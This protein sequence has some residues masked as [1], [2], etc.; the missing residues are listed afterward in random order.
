ME[1]RSIEDILKNVYDTWSESTSGMVL[2]VDEKNT[3][4]SQILSLILNEIMGDDMQADSVGL[5]PGDGLSERVLE[6]GREWYEVDLGSVCEVKGIDE[7]QR[8]DYVIPL[9]L[10]IPEHV[11]ES[12]ER[13]LLYQDFISTGC[14]SA[15][16]LYEMGK[17]ICGELGCEFGVDE[18]HRA[19]AKRW[20]E[21]R[22][23]D[24]LLWRLTQEREGMPTEE[25]WET[26]YQCTRDS[27]SGRRYDAAEV[28]GIRCNGMDEER[29]RRLA[30]DGDEL[31]RVNAVEH[32]AHGVQEKTLNVLYERMRKG[33][34]MVR[35]YAVKSFFDVW[36]NR[37]G[38][39]RTSVRKC[40][41]KMEKLYKKEKQPWVL[42]DY[43]TVRYLCGC[44]E[45]LAGLERILREGRG[46]FYSQHA[47]LHQ[48][49][50]VRNIYNEQ[51]INRMIEEAIPCMDDAYGMK[52]E[53]KKI[54]GEKEI[55]MVLIIDRKNAGLSQM[56]TYLSGEIEEEVWIESAGL[57]PAETTRDEVGE[58]LGKDNEFIR[59]HYYPKRVRQIYKYDFIVPLGIKLSPEKFPFQK[60]VPLFEN[61]DEKILDVEQ[62]GRMLESLREYI[63]NDLKK[64]CEKSK[65]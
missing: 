46:E 36:I 9:G 30:L 33:S 7:K 63:I 12:A 28:L 13:I 2:L 44:E 53:M 56:L 54:V 48:L 55:P 11:C 3:D 60:I 64:V 24:K 21:G 40:W 31:V 38:Y 18:A 42:A 57:E 16:E 58:K 39:T 20:L 1:E 22:F 52:E 14:E 37:N 51:K 26:V 59:R 6:A 65:I 27:D 43:E 50:Y 23:K 5:H 4:L 35:G 8:Y 29:L 61:V 32:L 45:G 15:Q 47:A 17:R 62:A 41:R 19:K 10:H 25:E 34:W 49:E